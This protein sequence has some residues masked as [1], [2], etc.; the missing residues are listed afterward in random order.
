MNEDRKFDIRGYFE[1]SVLEISRVGCM[2]NS[3]G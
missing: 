1:M 2:E 3:V